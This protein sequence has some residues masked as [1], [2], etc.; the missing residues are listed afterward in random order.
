MKF[1]YLDESGTGS[2]PFAIMVGVIA[3]SSRMHV[4]KLHWDGL[5]KVFSKILNRNIIEFHARDFYKGN[6]PWRN[7]DGSKRADIISAIFDWLAERKH[8]L[9]FSGVNKKL[10]LDAKK[11]NTRLKV[12]HSVWCF[13]GLH[14]LLVIQKAFQNHERNKGNT[15]FIFDNEI[16]E[17]THFAKLIKSPPSWIH[18]YYWS[19]STEYHLDQ[20]IDVPY[21]GDSKEVNLIQIADLVA[22]LLRRYVEINEK[23]IPARY[24]DE[25]EKIEKWAKHITKLSLSVSSR[26]PAVG[27]DECSELF[28]QYAP[29]SLRN[30][31]R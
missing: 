14:Q 22:Y 12:F 25:E 1:C 4:T 30:L 23:V 15:A 21:Y 5:L 3:D 2:E 24:H 26:Y 9:T 13:L 27:R 20:I 31:G 7:L 11:A 10:F 29:P 28:Y 18:S 6:S 17:E 8:R 19:D 16:R